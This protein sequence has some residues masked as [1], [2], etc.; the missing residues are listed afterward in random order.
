VQL[1]QRKR[2]SRLRLRAEEAERFAARAWFGVRRTEDEWRSVEKHD[3]RA[4]KQQR[5]KASGSV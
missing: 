2:E 4:S 3:L 1:R 5:F